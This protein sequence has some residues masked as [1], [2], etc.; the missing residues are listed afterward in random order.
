MKDDSKST[1]PGP[2]PPKLAE[3]RI[4]GCLANWKIRGLK[5][6]V[7]DEIDQLAYNQIRDIIREHF[8]K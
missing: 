5:E 2:T 1:I 8:N 3:L 6:K 7:W 4:L